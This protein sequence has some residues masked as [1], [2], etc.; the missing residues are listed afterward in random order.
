MLLASS[1]CAVGNLLC[2]QLGFNHYTPFP[3][4]AEA[5]TPIAKACLYT[6]WP[7]LLGRGNAVCRLPSVDDFLHMPHFRGLSDIVV[8]ARSKRFVTIF[9]ADKSC[10]SHDLHPLLLR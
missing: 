7:M 5:P 9:A 3:R 6:S 2:N 4:S 10:Q 1:M 8:D